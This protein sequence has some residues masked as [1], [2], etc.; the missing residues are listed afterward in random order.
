MLGTRS[1]SQAELLSILDTPVRGNGLI[2]LSHQLIAAKL[3]APGGTI[4][5]VSVAN[6][7]AVADAM[8][9]SKEVPAIGNGF[10]STASTSLLT[11]TLDQ[12]NNGNTPGGPPHCN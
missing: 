5:P 9:G 1:Y 6:A 2:S 8:I 4:I 10:L 3:N 11:A 7:M 12:F